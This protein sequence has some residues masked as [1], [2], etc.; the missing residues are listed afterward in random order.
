MIKVLIVDDDKNLCRCLVKQLP[1]EDME[2]TSPE[3]AYNGQH[4]W[5]IMQKTKMDLII[6]DLKMPVMDGMELCRMVREKSMDTIIVFLSAYEDFSIAQKAM[7]YGVKDY[8]LKP[9]NREGIENLKKII[10]RVA[11][12][13]RI[14][15]WNNML[16]SPEYAD[17]IR[18]ALHNQ[19]VSFF[20]EFF[21]NINRSNELFALNAS[22]YLLRI[23]NVYQQR[24]IETNARELLDKNEAEERIQFVQ[25]LFEKAMFDAS[26][27][28]R[29]SYI[30][31]QTKALVDENYFLPECSAAWISGKL[32]MQP[33][34]VGRLFSKK[35]GIGLTEY[36]VECRMKEASRLLLESNV[37]VNEIATKVGYCYS[38]YFTRAFR[39]RFN[40]SPSEYRY[41]Y[42]KKIAGDIEKVKEN[43]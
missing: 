32:Y 23:L 6:S 8:I 10:G 2:C 36:I 37:P 34:Y 5:E 7:R 31:K 16:F 21:P 24:N 26:D 30:V 22:M 11:N 42:G 20:Q 40:M 41:K 27:D 35:M 9:I 17:E 1:W 39:R 4:A 14:Q 33:A 28:S 29:M 3:V 12:E 25:A 19:D 15:E 43:L 38:N 13:K 18:K